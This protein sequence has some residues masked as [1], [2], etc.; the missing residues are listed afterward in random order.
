M[1][2][3][4]PRGGATSRSA[5]SARLRRTRRAAG[6]AGPGAVG[7]VAPGG[8][9][10]GRPAGPREMEEGARAGR[11]RG[12]GGRLAR[13]RGAAGG[14]DRLPQAQR[15]DDAHPAHLAARSAHF[16]GLAG[17]LEEPVALL[18]RRHE[19]TVG[20]GDVGAPRPPRPAPW[21]Q[22]GRAR[23][24][25]AAPH[26]ERRGERPARRDREFIA[27]LQTGPGFVADA[28]RSLEAVRTARSHGWRRRTGYL[29]AL[30]QNRW[31]RG[32]W[33]RALGRAERTVETLP[34]E[35]A[36]GRRRVRAG[37][38]AS[39]WSIAGRS[40]GPVPSSTR[41]SGCRRAPSGGPV[42]DRPG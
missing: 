1:T 11:G 8:S 22:R 19:R 24:A 28:E 31:F 27:T 34:V 36:A 42:G 38:R 15:G 20:R 33:D 26:A 39:S 5:C 6:V 25:G 14:G 13:R 40:A 12:G 9:G 35:R 23:A 2:R 41:S 32:D 16:L 3:R 30:T 18:A 4:W 17:R 7:R 10:R 37:T 21:T 29:V